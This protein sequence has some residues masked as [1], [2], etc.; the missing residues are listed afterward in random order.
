[1]SADAAPARTGA[2]SEAEAA[3][4]SRAATAASGS[5]AARRMSPQRPAGRELAS[6]R[7]AEEVDLGD[8]RPFGLGRQLRDPHEVVAVGVARRVEVHAGPALCGGDVAHVAP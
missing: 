2:A 5:R 1:M 3:A 4:G 8:L 6:A 7:A